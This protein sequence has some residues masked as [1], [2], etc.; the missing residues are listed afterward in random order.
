M[1][2]VYKSFVAIGKTLKLSPSFP[3]LNTVRAT[4]TAYSVPSY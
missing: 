1:L 3:P 2:L 4:F